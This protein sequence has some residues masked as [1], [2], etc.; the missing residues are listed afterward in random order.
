LISRVEAQMGCRRQ[1]PLLF[2]SAGMRSKMNTLASYRRA[3]EAGM[4]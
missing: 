1:S 2:T 3:S 4:S